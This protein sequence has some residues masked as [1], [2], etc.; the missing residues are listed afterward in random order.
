MIMILPLF[1]ILLAGVLAYMSAIDWRESMSEA[2]TITRLGVVEQPRQFQPNRSVSQQV[3]RLF[4][5]SRN[6]SQPTTPA[7]REQPPRQSLRKYFS[8][9]AEL[10]RGLQ[11]TTRPQPGTVSNTMG[12]C[13]DAEFLVGAPLPEQRLSRH[14]PA[15]RALLVLQPQIRHHIQ[16]VFD[17]WTPFSPEKR[18]R[19]DARVSAQARFRSN[20][21]TFVA[22]IA[23]GGTES[24][25]PRY[26]LTR[27]CFF[28]AQG[29][30][31]QSENARTYSAVHDLFAQQRQISQSVQIAGCAAE[32]CARMPHPLACAVNLAVTLA[33]LGAQKMDPRNCP[34]VVQSIKA[35]HESQRLVL[36]GYQNAE[37][38][39][40]LRRVSRVDTVGSM[41]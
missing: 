39:D 3:G 19:W 41:Y 7:R 16:P 15:L 18:A 37:Q 25:Q 33:S 4:E 11:S 34:V 12:F 40:A 1:M 2:A 21:R 29:M 13:T 36:L 35:L 26:N 14:S 17:S 10:T 30:I 6:I 27:D 32:A 28:A 22:L 31:C 20:Q 8:S 24:Q 23:S 9:C 38:F 5:R